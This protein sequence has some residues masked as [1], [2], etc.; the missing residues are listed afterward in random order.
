MA[1]VSVYNIEGKEVGTIDLSDAVFG[2]EVNEHLVHMAVVSS[3]QT[4]V[5]EHRKRKLVLKFPEVEE[6]HGDRKEQVMQD[7]V[8]QD[9]HSGQ[10]VE[11]YSLQHQEITP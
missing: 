1:N 5:R 11:L 9:L 6:N 2:V 7:R 10:A 4:N 8:L 3:L